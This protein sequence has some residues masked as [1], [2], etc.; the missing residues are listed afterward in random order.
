MEKLEVILYN[1]IG[2]AIVAILASLYVNLKRY[3][4]RWRLK[5]IFGNDA[6]S[7]DKYYIVYAKLF[8]REIKDKNTGNPITHPYIKPPAKGKK[9][10]LEFSMEYPVSSCE[11]RASQYLSSFFSSHFK[12]KLNLISDLEIVNNYNISFISLGSLSNYKTTDVFDNEAN[13]LVKIDNNDFVSVKNGKKLLKLDAK[14]DYGLILKI[15]PSECPNRVWIVCAG[16]GETGTSSTAWYL[17]NNWQEILIKSKSWLNPFGLLKTN[18]F[19]AIIRSLPG[20]D[21]SAKLIA[22]YRNKKEIAK[23]S[24]K[25]QNNDEKKSQSSITN[26]II[27]AIPSEYNIN[28]DQALPSGV[29]V[30][31]NISLTKSSIE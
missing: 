26:T 14:Y 4:R 25:I 3:F 2:G 20:K 17:S 12:N 13:D 5:R 11:V 27:S 15:R 6:D 10:F 1:V 21:E 9:Q 24:K 18:N 29:S 31:P 28:E 22:F 23:A 8:L 19:A 7:S 30:S 16:L